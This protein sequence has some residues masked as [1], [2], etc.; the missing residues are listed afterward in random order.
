MLQADNSWAVNRIR[1]IALGR[2]NCLSAA[3]TRAGK[4]AADVMRL[5]QSARLNGQDPRV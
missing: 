5:I 3:T 2:N 4:Q 1:P